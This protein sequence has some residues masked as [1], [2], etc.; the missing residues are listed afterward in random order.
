MSDDVVDLAGVIDELLN[1]K[2]GRKLISFSVGP[3]V[4]GRLE[5][6]ILDLEDTESG[7]KQIF[8]TPIGDYVDDA[9]SALLPQSRSIH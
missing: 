5:V 7:K 8:G 2:T 4:Q 3:K 6:R 9:A 1:T